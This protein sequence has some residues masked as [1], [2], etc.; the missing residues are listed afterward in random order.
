MIGTTVEFHSFKSDG[1]P[2]D[3]VLVNEDGLMKFI[4]E[5]T[6]SPLIA[7]II[8]SNVAEEM[9]VDI[10]MTYDSSD[11]G[12]ESIVAFGNYCPIKGGTHVDGFKE[13][14]A[15][16]F[17]NYMNKVY[18]TG[19]KTKATVINSDIYTGLRAVVSASHLHPIFTGQSKEILSNAELKEYTKDVIFNALDEWSKSNP[20]DLQ[21]VCAYL[22]DVAEIRLSADKQKVKLTNKYSGSSLTGLPRKYVAPTGTKDDG[23]ELFIVEGDSAKGSLT[24]NRINKKQGV[25]PIRGKIPNAFEKS[26]ND[27]LSNAEVAGIISILD[28]GR[29][30]NYGKNMDL[31]LCPFEKIIFATDADPDGKHIKKLLLSFFLLYLRPLIEDGR[32]YAAVPPLYGIPVGKG[33]YQYFTDK[34]D[35]I[36]Y[37]LKQFNKTY[38]VSD[39][40]GRKMSADKVTE[41]IFRNMDYVYELESLASNHALNPYLLEKSLMEYKDKNMF[42]HLKKEYRFL[43]KTTI[44]GVDVI[45]GLVENKINTVFMNDKLLTESKN[46]LRYI[47]VINLDHQYVQLNGQLVTIYTL[48]KEFNK[49]EPPSINRYKGLG[50]MDGKQLFDSTVDPEKRTLIRYTINDAVKELEQIKHFENNKN[51]LLVGLDNLSRMDVIG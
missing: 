24:N 15:N 32:V 10:L 49:F 12:D 3:D 16:F 44:N 30:K 41:I 45:Q 4:I 31:S 14:L 47:E 40:A 8:I 7:P 2:V 18:L 1:T 9:K 34:I 50:E 36:N 33:K 39:V 17:R 6:E 51:E 28:G 42:N 19:K 35:Y 48:M 20:K 25:F 46:V 26:K 43:N 27:F 37:V 38:S 13:G 11:I 5:S 22:K 21:K 29:G 23:L